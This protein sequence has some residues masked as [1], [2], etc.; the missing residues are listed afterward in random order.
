MLRSTWEYP[1][2]SELREPK[3]GGPGPWREVDWRG[4]RRTLAAV[5]AQIEG[6]LGGVAPLGARDTF[7][8]ESAACEARAGRRVL[9]RWEATGSVALPD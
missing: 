6:P 9:D 4:L 7:A 1:T 8:L 2:G 3:F 5:K